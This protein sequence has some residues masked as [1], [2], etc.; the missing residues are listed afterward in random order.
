MNTDKIE[1]IV[2]FRIERS[3]TI[4]RRVHLFFHSGSALIAVIIF[5]PVINNFMSNASQSGLSSYISLLTTDSASV[6][7][8]WKVLGL[9]I[10]ESIPV[11]DTTIILGLVLIIGNAVHRAKL[12]IPARFRTVTHV[13]A[14]S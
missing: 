10:I 14:L 13:V 4:N 8:S 3:R 5:V 7:G 1:K 6:L 12:Y 11:L 9:S 2:M